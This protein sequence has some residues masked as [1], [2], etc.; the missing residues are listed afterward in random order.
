MI[1]CIET[2]H[3]LNNSF[4]VLYSVIYLQGKVNHPFLG[5]LLFECK[6]VVCDVSLFLFKKK[7]FYLKAWVLDSLSVK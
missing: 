6:S 7:F 4:R 5:I 2:R 3:Y 1:P